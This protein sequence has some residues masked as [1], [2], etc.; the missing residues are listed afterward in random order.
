MMKDN[1]NKMSQG[2]ETQGED[3]QDEMTNTGLSETWDEWPVY[4]RTVP[5]SYIHT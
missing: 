3:D 5:R 1:Y 4:C 2:S